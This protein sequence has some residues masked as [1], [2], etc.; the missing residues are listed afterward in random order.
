MGERTSYA[1]GTFSWADLAT[2]DPDGAKAFYG[3]LFGWEGEDMPAGGGATYTMLRL[4]GRD[5]AALYRMRDEQREIG[6]PPTWLAYVT[7]DDADAMAHRAAGL[8]A[9][10]MGEA[11][12]VV[13]SGRMAI[14]RDPLGAMLALWQPK[15]NIGAGIVNEPGALCW[16][17]LSTPD[18]EASRAFYAALFGWEIEAEG[19]GEGD[20]RAVFND[21]RANGG[22]MRLQA[23]PGTPPYW[24]VY[25]AVADMD[26]GVAR[27][28][29]LGGRV[30]R[31]PFDVPAGRF[32]VVQDPQGATFSLFAGELDP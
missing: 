16:N 13:D 15:R 32:A 30:L 23:P 6:M 21:G 27:V 2:T 29:E 8:G 4:A 9:T 12:D 25:F 26:D 28:R 10:V 24:S 20:Y 7:A 11:F 3:A 19:R 31:E 5:A 1:P 18:V 14:V 17:D 22:M